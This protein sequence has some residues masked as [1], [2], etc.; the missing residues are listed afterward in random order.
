VLAGSVA[1]LAALAAAAPASA[2]HARIVVQ[3][4]ISGASPFTAAACGVSGDPSP[5]SEAEPFI[6]ADPTSDGGLI[7]VFQQDRFASNGGALSNLAAFTRDGGATSGL[8]RFPKLSKC[9]GGTRQRTSDPWISIGGDGTAYAANLTFDSDVGGEEAGLAG[10]TQLWSSVSHDGGRTWGGP[11][12]IIDRGVYDDREAITADPQRAG[13]AYVAW[14]RRDG[15]FGETGTAQFSRTTDGGATWSAPVSFYAPGSLKLPDPILITVMPD[16]SLV[17]TL[18]VIDARSQVQS[19]PLP[20]DLLALR[21]DDLGKTWKGPYRIGVTDS[22]EPSDPDSGSSLRALPIVSTAVD[23]RGTLYTAWNDI[24][25]PQSS[26]IRVARSTD[27][28][29]GWSAPVDVAKP[30][31]QAFLPA[32]GV[33]E[34]GT[35]GV[36][37]DDSRNDK[38]GD[39]Q[40]TVDV[41]FAHSHDGGRTWSEDHLA[42]PFDA[43]TASETS[44]TGV[45]GHFLGDYQGLA[46][47]TGGQ[48]AGIYAA[49]RPLAT[50]GPSDVFLARVDTAAAAARRSRA[51]RL[52]VSPRRVRAR[53]RATVTFRA[54]LG[55]R[56]ARAVKIAFAGRELHTNATGRASAR[57][58]LAHPGRRRAHASRRGL[59]SANAFVTAR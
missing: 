53:R 27:G 56:P 52:T 1:A 54:T 38:P 26:L 48:F 18:N 40:F 13:Y 36:M 35:V 47:L 25:S 33:S 32:L 14:V 5:D 8:A 42:G 29:R 59:R 55:A 12:R 22:T 16:G 9:T 57:V 3:R 10:P 15:A 23:S 21:S 4:A 45:A 7:G 11:A 50:H 37:W 31:G 17:A 19:Q 58:R 34:D 28:G 20:F 43:L 49:S 51:L 30:A 24:K 46:G 41:F 2:D 6:A 44:S 39:G